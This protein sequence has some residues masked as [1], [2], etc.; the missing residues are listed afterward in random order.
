MQAKGQFE[1]TLTPCVED[2]FNAG[3]LLINKQYSG[4]LKGIGQGQ[5]ISHRVEA[6]TSVYSA[7]EHFKGELEGK[8]GEFTLW[9]NGVMSATQ[10][11]LNIVIVEGSGSGELQGIT[12]KLEIIQK[13]GKHFYELEYQQT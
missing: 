7:I 12:G 6:G 11:Q 9:H 8:T 3:R 4:D 13:E 5:M 10:Q 2:E 1:I